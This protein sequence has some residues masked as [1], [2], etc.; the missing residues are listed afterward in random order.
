MSGRAENGSA[1]R[2]V[3][4]VFGAREVDEPDA[5]AAGVY[6]QFEKD[7]DAQLERCRRLAEERGYAPA[8]S[9]VVSASQPAL[10]RLLEW[11]DDPGCEVVLVASARVLARIES[12]WP[13]W[14]ELMDR[15]KVAG[16]RVEAVPYPEPTYPGEELPK[17]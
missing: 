6:C 17:R 8:G 3:C 2:A 12:S 14:S 15:L 4:L 16:A 9:C 1:S 11:A 7:W 5:E 13:D 10:S